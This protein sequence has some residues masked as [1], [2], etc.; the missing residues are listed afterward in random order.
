MRRI[1]TN[2]KFFLAFA[3]ITTISLGLG[4]CSNPNKSSAD[5]QELVIA[6]PRV[7]EFN[8]LKGY[9]LLAA[10]GVTETLVEVDSV[11]SLR[12]NLAERWETVDEK[13]WR[14]YLRKGVQFHDGTR[15]DAQAAKFSLERYLKAGPA[16]LDIPPTEIKIED[17]Y[18]LLLTAKEPGLLLPAYFTN[19]A[20]SIISPN[21]FSEDG[22]FI[23]PI[24][25]GPF[26]F[27]SGR[28]RWEMVLVRNERYWGG[29]ARLKKVVV[30]KNIDPQTRIFMLE[31]GEAGVIQ[32]VPTQEV[33]RL[34]ASPKY[35]IL[36]SRFPGNVQ[37]YF[38]VIKEPFNDLKVRKAVNYAI[39]RD[40]LVHFFE[41]HVIPAKAPFPPGLPWSVENLTGYAYDK[42]KASRLLA[43]AGWQMGA[44]RT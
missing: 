36:K 26:K 31:A 7:G 43:K 21:S 1:N 18:T 9:N 5:V 8:P 6:V 16:W 28:A 3:L 39:D 14:F 4:A 20:S 37:L 17:E 22:R 19:R 11:L 32:T 23:K 24:G 13:R 30:K 40:A 12:P 35:N 41:G 29:N 10:F 44:D 27:G 38:N 2:I 42:E 33:T 34:Q 15:F 25:T